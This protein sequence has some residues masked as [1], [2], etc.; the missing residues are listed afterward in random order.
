MS[1][2]VE[3]FQT[4]IAFKA[5][6]V[7]TASGDLDRAEGLANFK[8]AILR[9][10]VTV[11]GALVHRPNYGIGIQRYLGKLNSIAAQQ[12]LAQEIREQ[13]EADERTEKVTGIQVKLDDNNPFKVVI[14]VRVKPV[15]YDEVAISIT[16]FSEAG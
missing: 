8:E 10:C 3:V 4:D 11:R 7:K 15:G 9:R 1:T 16:P 14:I 5:D 2:E 6:F 13:L 12:Q